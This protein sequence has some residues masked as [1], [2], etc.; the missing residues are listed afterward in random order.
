MGEVDIR[1]QALNV[2]RMELLGARVIPVASGTRT[3]K[4]AVNEALRDWVERVEDTFYL[5]GSIVGPH[6]Y[7]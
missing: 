2:S 4:D 6:P 7:P 5:L 1:R 3:L